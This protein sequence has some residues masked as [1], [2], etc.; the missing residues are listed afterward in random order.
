MYQEE[1]QEYAYW[2]LAYKKLTEKER[3]LITLCDQTDPNDCSHLINLS[4][5]IRPISIHSM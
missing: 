5:A 1:Y 4:F 3:G 2:M